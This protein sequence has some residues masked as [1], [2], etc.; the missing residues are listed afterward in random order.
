MG[1]KWSFSLYVCG[2]IR[3]CL[4]QLSSSNGRPATGSQ[5]HVAPSLA[6]MLASSPRVHGVEKP[7]ALSLSLPLILYLA[8]S[9]AQPSRARRAPSFPFLNASSLTTSCSHR[10][11]LIP[12]TSRP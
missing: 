7:S 9:H 2:S 12:S 10:L 8:F 11:R 6:C 1:G 3:F 5:R 4:N